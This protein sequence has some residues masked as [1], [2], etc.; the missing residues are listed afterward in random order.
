MNTGLIHWGEIMKN[1]PYCSAEIQENAQFCL[2]C[3]NSLSQKEI[4]KK[5]K[6][7]A[8]TYLFV[9]IAVLV[10]VSILVSVLFFVFFNKNRN[11]DKEETTVSDSQDI[12]VSYEDF[13][14]QALM[15]T[16]KLGFN[17]LWNPQELIQTHSGEMYDA[18][19]CDINIPEA[20]LRIIFTNGG[21]E[22]L[23]VISDLTDET[24]IDGINLY[25]C[26]LSGVENYTF[27]NYHQMMTNTDM[28]PLKPKGTTH[29]LLED[30]DFPDP[31]KNKTDINTEA[32]IEYRSSA[33]DEGKLL[34]YEIRTRIYNGIKYYDI[35]MLNTYEYE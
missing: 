1:C 34:L 17:E 11:I 30:I 9:I 21:E 18:Y 3:M 8:K 14:L 23:T 26:I 25:E 6:P 4:N 24:F 22:I 31:A 28:Y 16:A 15:A 7:A 13:R 27:T 2:Y 32:A 29:T 20:D 10:A 5:N 35:F 33:T 19:S 12:Y